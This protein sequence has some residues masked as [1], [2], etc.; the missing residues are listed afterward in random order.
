[1]IYH[2]VFWN[3]K[4]EAAGATAAENAAK[5]QELLQKLPAVIPQI[6]DLAVGVDFNRSNAAWDIAL[7]STFA[8][9][10]DLDAYQN[11]PEH[12]KVGEFI[13]SVVAERAVV[14]FEA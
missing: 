3:L 13:R 1:M 4:P 11:H 12:L 8:S 5:M 2:L 9:A 7:H 6:Q 14:D 10:A